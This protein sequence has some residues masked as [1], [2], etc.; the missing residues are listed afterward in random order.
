MVNPVE[1]IFKLITCINPNSHPCVYPYVKQTNKKRNERK[2]KLKPCKDHIMKTVEKICFLLKKKRKK[3]VLFSFS[4][5]TR[6]QIRW[7]KENK[8]LK[9]CNKKRNI[10]IQ[11]LTKTL[12]P[13]KT[14]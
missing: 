1:R 10:L 2:K 8:E 14:N 12:F 4:I 6:G 5:Y 3:S 7:R 13:C 9:M 11:F